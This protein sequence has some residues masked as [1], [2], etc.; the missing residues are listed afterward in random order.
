MPY[1]HVLLCAFYLSR[2][3]IICYFFNLFYQKKKV[4]QAHFFLYAAIARCLANHNL[5]F[6]YSDS[7]SLST[8][9]PK[10]RAFRLRPK[11]TSSSTMKSLSSNPKLLRWSSGFCVCFSWLFL[12][13]F[14]FCRL[15][16]VFLNFCFSWC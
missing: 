16:L 6:T 13:R 10:S 9:L 12:S 3:M 15:F 1:A 4:G 14:A 7:S 5:N 11:V 8:T 2:S